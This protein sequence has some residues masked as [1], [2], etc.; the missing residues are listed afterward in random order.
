MH[1]SY[2]NILI[3]GAS[4]GIGH[5]LAK[6][7]AVE[8][9]NLILLARRKE[10]LDELKE[11]IKS[12]RNSILTYQCDVSK[13]D[14]VSKVFTEIRKTVDHID[15][16]ILNAGVGRNLT[17]E[18]FESELAEETFQINV[19]GIIYCIEELLK[20]F[21]PKKN[22]TIVGI[23]SIA[24]VRGFP[25]SGI[26]CSSKAAVSTL[27]E[28]FRV[29]FKPHNI[30]VITVRPG[31]VRTQM[32]KKNDFKMPFLMNT[33]KA[34]KIIINGIKKEKKVIEFPFGTVFGGRFLKFLPNSIYD[35]LAS[36]GLPKDKS[37][38]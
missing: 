36:K 17:V 12:D 3:T 35:Y 28:S 8:E 23:S 11:L 1:L 29:E 10:L 9:C 21:I 37:K 32:I 7:L 4:S 33:D 18:N 14:E 34:A 15:I 16:G 20:D 26:Y 31:W 2:Q 5:E 22:G 30:K 13:K 27:L 6:Q 25:K 19:L 24:D 38:I